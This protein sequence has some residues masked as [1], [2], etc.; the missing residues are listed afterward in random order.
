MDRIAVVGAGAVGS[1]Y[2]GLLAQAGH[3][4]VLIGRDAHVRAIREQGLRIRRGDSLTTVSVEAST[5][6]A[7]VRGASQVLLCVKSRDTLST[8]QALKPLISPDCAVLSLQNGVANPATLAAELDCAVL[9]T[10]VY[11]ATDLVAPGEVTHLG[12]GAL[13]MGPWSARPIAP[14]RLEAIAEQFRASGVTVD[15]SERV[16]D[17]MWGKL[18][19][20]CAYNAI[21]AIT[22]L[23]YATLT[24]TEDIRDL[25]RTVVAEVVAV[26]RAQGVRFTDDIE[27]ATWRIAQTMPRQR[28]STAQD[29]A[30]G[31]PTEIDWINGQIVRDGRALGIPTPANHSLWSLVR[32]M[33][34]SGQ[35]AAPRPPVHAR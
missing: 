8:A 12:G 20:N 7:A 28:S 3:P 14:E 34:Q 10:V 31:R 4:V 18:M 2:G 29:L 22:Q 16:L 17:A 11:V 5:E 32:L 27:G 35:L 15:V 21:S 23:D 13:V 19:A 6:L 26:G 30:R 24:A 25:M 9:P 33:E 1:F